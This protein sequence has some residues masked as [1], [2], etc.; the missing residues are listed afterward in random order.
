M[1]V[2]LNSPLDV[3]ISFTLSIVLSLFHCTFDMFCLLIYIIIFTFAK[4]KTYT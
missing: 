4:K 3:T 2:Y 1:L